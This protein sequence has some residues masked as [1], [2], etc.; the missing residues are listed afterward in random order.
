M[1][2]WRPLRQHK[3][4]RS[5]GSLPVCVDFCSSNI[6]LREEEKLF[7]FSQFSLSVIMKLRWC[8]LKWKCYPRMHGCAN[9]FKIPS[10][11]YSPN[12]VQYPISF[13]QNLIYCA[14]LSFHTYILLWPWMLKLQLYNCKINLNTNIVDGPQINPVIVCLKVR[15]DKYQEIFNLIC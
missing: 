3:D 1:Q 11:W 8:P 9:K 10:R 6:F 2:F 12:P 14:A 15:K 4:L 7:H 5:Q 13:H